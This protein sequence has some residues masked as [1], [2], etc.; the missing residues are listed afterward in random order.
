MMSA[1]EWRLKKM[2]LTVTGVGLVRVL[3][4]T[5]VVWTCGRSIVLDGQT[6][7]QYSL[8]W[9]ASLD[10]SKIKLPILD[11]GATRRVQ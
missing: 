7:Q 10:A 2:G 11:V 1:S 4:P 3:Y 8:V 5:D 6:I 9:N